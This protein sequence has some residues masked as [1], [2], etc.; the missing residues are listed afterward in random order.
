MDTEFDIYSRRGSVWHRWDPHVHTPGTALNDQYK[1]D[2]PWD[3]FLMRIPR[4]RDHSFR[5]IVTAHSG[6]W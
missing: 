4:E 5:L 1:G 6:R 2:D 3:T